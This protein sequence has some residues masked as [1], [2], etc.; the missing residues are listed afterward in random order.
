MVR[1]YR[2]NQ[3]ALTSPRSSAP[4][5]RPTIGGLTAL[6]IVANP[7][8]KEPLI[9]LTDGDYVSIRS[10]SAK[11]ELV[12][13]GTGYYESSRN[14]YNKPAEFTGF[15]RAHTPDGVTVK[16]KGYGTAL[17]TALALGAALTDDGDVEID[18]YQKGQG[19]SSWTENRSTE[20]DH[21]WNAA[22]KTGLT[23]TEVE[24]IE[25]K[26]ENVDIDLDPDDLNRVASV[27]GTI[28]Y[29]N[30]VN[31]D[32]EKTEEQVYDIY[33]WESASDHN[34]IVC[35]FVVEVPEGAS[36]SYVFDVLIDKDDEASV[37][38]VNPIALAALDVRE[39]SEE[40]AKLIGLQYLE[41][42]LGDR[43]LDEF[44]QRYQQKLDP[45]MSGAQ[46]RLFQANAAAG[47]GLVEEARRESGW[48]EIEELP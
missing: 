48:D 44:R 7:K 27:E 5:E 14:E 43:A 9:V 41:A 15:P 29:V 26:E 16:G 46:L 4:I 19:I 21:W 12:K 8:T 20:A 45:S 18:M 6:G 39:L 2:K 42:E 47:L 17:Y 24:E 13:I 32:I 37:M 36:L 30:T 31:V 38:R 34:L 33:K 28:T 3:F 10:L 40:G 1:R 35:E 11:S 23:A 25:E 22:K